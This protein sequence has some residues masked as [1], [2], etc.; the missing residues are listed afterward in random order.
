MWFS[1]FVGIFGSL[2]YGSRA[3][4]EKVKRKK[5]GDLA[6]RV[7]DI[8]KWWRENVVWTEEGRNIIKYKISK[9]TNEE[10]WEEVKNVYDDIFSKYDLTELKR[11]S[12]WHKELK[13][14]NCYN[15]EPTRTGLILDKKRATQ[16]ILAKHGLI[17]GAQGFSNTCKLT[18]NFLPWSD[19]CPLID[20]LVRKW[21]T[22][23]L[24]RHKLDIDLKI[25][26][27]KLSNGNS[28]YY[29]CWI[30]G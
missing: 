24:K 4:G 3:I 10:V 13:Y 9:M 7:C 6:Q 27:E 8:S 1:F 15:Y 11:L 29:W 20:I 12:G 21:C 26:E 23:E 14:K 28:L 25:K 18:P 17:D 16:I 5:T 2:F 30:I 22:E 19:A